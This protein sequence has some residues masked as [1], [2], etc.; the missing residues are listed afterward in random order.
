MFEYMCVYI[1]IDM[2]RYR[3]FTGSDGKVSACNMGD[4]GMATHS[5][6]LAR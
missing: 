4:P 1:K 2:E 3:G 5:S 6:I